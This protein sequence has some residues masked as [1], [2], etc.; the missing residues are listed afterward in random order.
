MDRFYI[1]TKVLFGKGAIEKLH[2]ENLPFR[3]ALI[4]TTSGTSVKKYGYLD[5][6]VA[7]L[8]KA[9]IASVLFDKVQGN[10]THKTV[11]EGAA[12]CRQEGCDLVVGLGGGS[13]IDSAKAIAYMATNEGTLWDYLGS[14]SGKGKA[15]KNKPL[16]IIAVN[17][18]A[19]TGTETDPWSVI[20]DEELDEKIGWGQEGAF[21]LIGI[22]DTDMMLTVPK[23][24]SM[25]QGFDAFFHLS[26]GYVHPLASPLSRALSLKGMTLIKD[27][28]PKVCKNPEDEKARENMALASMIGGMV[29][30][31]SSCTFEHTLEH[32]ISSLFHGVIHGAGLIAISEA[33]F[34]HLASS[35]MKNAELIEMAKIFDPKARSAF[36]FANGLHELKVRCHV[37]KVDLKSFGIEEKDLGRIAKKALSLTGDDGKTF[38]DPITYSYRDIVNILE[39]SY[40][41]KLP[42]KRKK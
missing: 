15:F 19:G 13:P 29:E 23:V 38:S 6:T 24:L 14:G 22:D 32:A 12:L 2:E 31:Y 37:E 25:Y 16:P 33:Y 7:E 40:E 36:S 21:P 27:N 1:P 35:K 34:N 11:L 42:K 28:L 20:T 4:V 9:K 8:K 18:T 17:T 5:K 26:E 3:K 10:P 39:D 41:V 30:C